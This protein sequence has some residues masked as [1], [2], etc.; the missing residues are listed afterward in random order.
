MERNFNN[1]M[2][3]QTIK[4]LNSLIKQ[5]KSAV[6]INGERVIIK[7]VKSKTDYNGRNVCDI[8]ITFFNK[9][10]YESENRDK[11]EE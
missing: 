8:N 10:Y 11:Q 1:D 5:T 9:N 6:K 2:L 3:V 4:Y 7:S